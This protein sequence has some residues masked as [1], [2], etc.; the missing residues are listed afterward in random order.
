MQNLRE[1]VVQLKRERELYQRQCQEIKDIYEIAI[2]RLNEK[3][4]YI[5]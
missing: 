2:L 4:H 3:D 1:Q 5:R